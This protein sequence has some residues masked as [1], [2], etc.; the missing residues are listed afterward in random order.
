MGF[1]RLSPN[2]LNRTVLRLD[3]VVRLVARKPWS[4]AICSIVRRALHLGEPVAEGLRS[5]SKSIECDNERSDPIP[6]IIR[7]KA[8]RFSDLRATSMT[9]YIISKI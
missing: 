3:P 9:D 2:E 1:D 4:V 8:L 5:G 7:R 6:V